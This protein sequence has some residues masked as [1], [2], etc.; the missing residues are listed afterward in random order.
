M[1]Q[2]SR[3]EVD[4]ALHKMRVM[5]ARG[6]V[7]DDETMQ[8]EHVK[9]LFA[10]QSI[11]R[12]RRRIFFDHPLFDGF[13]MLASTADGEPFTVGIARVREADGMEG[14]PHKQAFFTKESDG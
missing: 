13:A 9:G 10:P 14:L 11:L 7:A 6:V 3:P 8:K 1:T 4:N 5:L 12:D 2:A